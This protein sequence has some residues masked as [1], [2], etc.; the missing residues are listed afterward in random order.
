[1]ARATR[2]AALPGSATAPLLTPNAQAL[3]LAVALFIGGSARLWPVK[4]PDAARGLATRRRCSP[5]F[6]ACSS[7]RSAA[8]PNSSRWR[9]A[10]RGQPWFAAAGAT[11]GAFAVAFVAAVLGELAWMRIRFR[12]FRIVTG[13]LFLVA[14]A[15]IG[16]GRAAS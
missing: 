16:A 1:M 6:S 15:V 10:V 7:S 5:A 9:F 11:A 8:R 13:L 14:G 12:G 2:V 4:P 3:F